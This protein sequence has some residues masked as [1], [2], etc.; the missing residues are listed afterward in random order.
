M[1]KKNEDNECFLI[2]VA[3]VIIKIRGLGTDAL[4]YIVLI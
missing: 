1:K 4:L 2:S 3:L